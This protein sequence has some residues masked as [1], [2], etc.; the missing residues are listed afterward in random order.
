M[1]KT[2][3]IILLFVSALMVNAQNS[4]SLKT[5]K[6]KHSIGLQAGYSSAY[7]LSYRMDYNNWGLMTVFSPRINGNQQVYSFGITALRTVHKGD[8]ASLFL[9]LGEHYLR[10]YRNRS[11]N[12][13]QLSQN[14][15][16]AFGYGIKINFSS[17]VYLNLQFGI[18]VN[19]HKRV[20]FNY[21]RL[22]KVDEGAYLSPDG[23]IGLFYS[24]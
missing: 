24:F 22:P 4:D 17:K 12:Y 8:K 23:G 13:E 1:K 10:N 21:D 9:Y 16:T 5:S 20:Y 7:G 6:F 15:I 11:Y 18:G 19:Y 14:Y 3:L 2:I